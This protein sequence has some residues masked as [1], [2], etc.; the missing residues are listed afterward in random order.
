MTDTA[1]LANV[2]A[3]SR[4]TTILFT[5]LCTARTW[6]CLASRN[7]DATQLD[8]RFDVWHDNDINI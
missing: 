7:Y 3:N 2:I 1:R 8:A 6:L 4:H 5:N